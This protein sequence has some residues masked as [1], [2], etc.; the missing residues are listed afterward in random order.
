MEINTK[1]FSTRIIGA[2][3][4]QPDAHGAI[5]LPVYRNAAFEYP[6]SNSIAAAFQRKPEM[7]TYSRISN[8]S[9]ANLEAKIQAASGGKHVLAL[10]SGMAAISASFFAL[11]YAGANIVSSPRLFGNTLSFFK[12]TLADFG[13]ETRFVNADNPDEIAAAIDENTCAVFVEIITNPCLEIADLPAIASVVRPKGV[14][15]VVDTTLTPWCGFDAAACGIDIE[16]VSTTKYISGGATSI[17]GAI[18]D[19]ATFDETASRKLSRM[20]PPPEGRTRFTQKLRA[21]IGRNLGACMSPDTA[22]LQSLGM[23]T[24]QMRYETASAS[25]YAVARRL[26]G[27][28]KI[29][30]VNYPALESSPYK[31][32]ADKLFFGYPGAMFTL[33]LPDRAACFRFMDRLEIFRRATN[34]FDNKSLVI[35]PESTIYGTFSPEMKKLAGIEPGAIRFSIGLEDPDDLVAD[36]ENALSYV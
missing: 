20:P 24:L 11:A 35:H 12:Y 21:E 13:V 19:R 4:A 27:R 1:K 10:A 14:P 28:E 31:K 3:F 16:V 23:E 7:H 6:D 17:G 22:C 29:L 25:A 15:L 26:E 8:P 34:L 2:K 18:I 36:I 9:V 5:S 33:S 30:A 32:I